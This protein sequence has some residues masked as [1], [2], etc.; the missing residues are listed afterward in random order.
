LHEAVTHRRIR[1]GGDVARR[2]GVV[3]GPISGC[4]AARRGAATRTRS[5]LARCDTRQQSSR[6]VRA[7]EQRVC[8]RKRRTSGATY[9]ERGH[10]SG[11]AVESAD[12]T[13]AFEK[14]ARL[15]VRLSKLEIT[16]EQREF[17]RVATR[18][19]KFK[20]FT[21]KLGPGNYGHRM[22]TNR[23]QY[24]VGRAPRGHDR[25]QNVRQPARVAFMSRSRRSST[26]HA[27]RELDRHLLPELVVGP[28]EVLEDHVLEVGVGEE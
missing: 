2:P 26:A 13:N 11:P 22:A 27:A 25:R 5:R 1:R 3:T 14:A 19:A 9:T 18:Y 16:R 7:A 28:A 4:S 17:E 20:N 23:Y 8:Q 21:A 10:A 24:T 15:Y 12:E 6:D